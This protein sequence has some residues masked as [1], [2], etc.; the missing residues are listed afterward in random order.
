MDAR[1]GGPEAPTDARRH[2]RT[3]EVI[4][5]LNQAATELIS[6]AVRAER[7]AHDQ[8]NASFRAEN[9]LALLRHDVDRLRSAIGVARQL[10]EAAL[11]LGPPDD[12]RGE[13]RRGLGLIDEALSETGED[14]GD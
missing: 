13:L 11:E 8:R 4:A 3:Q 14:G 2:E 5:A 10:L 7:D 12:L 1:D 6:R 9:E